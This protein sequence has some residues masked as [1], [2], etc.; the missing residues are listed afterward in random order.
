MRTAFFSQKVDEK[1]NFRNLSVDK[2]VILR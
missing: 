2:M 1:H